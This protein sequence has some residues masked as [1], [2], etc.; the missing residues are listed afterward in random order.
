[1]DPLPKS[2]HH[3]FS[4]T[5]LKMVRFSCKV[6]Q[7][8]KGEPFGCAWLGIFRPQGGALW[9]RF[10]WLEHSS[11]GS[12]LLCSLAIISQLKWVK[13]P[14]LLG[15]YIR[16]HMLLLGKISC[17]SYNSKFSCQDGTVMECS[18]CFVV[19]NFRFKWVKDHLLSR[20][21]P[22]L[23]MTEEGSL[24]SYDNNLS[25]QDGT[26]MEFRDPI[27][28]FYSILRLQQSTNLVR[29]RVHGGI[30]G[31]GG[32]LVTV[33]RHRDTGGRENS[34]LDVLGDPGV[35]DRIGGEHLEQGRVVLNYGV[36]GVLVELHHVEMGAVHTVAV[37]E[38]GGLEVPQEVL[39]VGVVTSLE[40]PHIELGTL[41]TTFQSRGQQVIIGALGVVMGKPGD[42]QEL[43]SESYLFVEITYLATM[44]AFLSGVCLD[45]DMMK[46]G[47]IWRPRRVDTRP[48]RMSTSF[49]P[50]LRRGMA[51]PLNTRDLGFRDKMYSVSLL[52]FLPDHGSAVQSQKLGARLL[53][54]TVDSLRK[55]VLAGLE[56]LQL[57]GQTGK[58]GFDLGHG[59]AGNAT[60]TLKVSQILTFWTCLAEGQ[61]GGLIN[62]LVSTVMYCVTG[63]K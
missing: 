34:C 6:L 40:P 63:W 28:L 48:T 8:F 9:S 50:F 53:V 47:G 33:G 26:V 3:V 31:G 35:P 16:L 20:G 23:H 45:T 61:I 19:I 59:F 4:V 58:L 24:F 36:G 11:K 27:K 17:F 39:Q 13:D 18:V 62:I 7:A 56:I 2:S 5:E 38:A 57:L 25:F 29:V 51:G 60:F 15:G 1:M 21:K 14:L 41:H 12:L 44:G 52:V 43:I 54:M 46:L 22:G 32:G 37:D 42:N 30:L 49:S 55:V 10:S